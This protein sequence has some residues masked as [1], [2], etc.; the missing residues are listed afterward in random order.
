MNL[1]RRKRVRRLSALGLLLQQ[2]ALE[3]IW[4][5]EVEP[6]FGAV[7]SADGDPRVVLQRIEAEPNGGVLLVDVPDAVR[8]QELSRPII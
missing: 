3:L 5:A 2:V 8:G 4:V 7:V 1:R 6:E